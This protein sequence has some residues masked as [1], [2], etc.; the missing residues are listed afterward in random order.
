MT[1]RFHFSASKLIIAPYANPIAL[2]R[3]HADPAV[4]SERVAGDARVYLA[5]RPGARATATC[6][7]RVPGAPDVTDHAIELMRFDPDPVFHAP[8]RG[9]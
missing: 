6:I 8:M 4:A 1:A 2:T 7:R 9:R 5:A 3:F